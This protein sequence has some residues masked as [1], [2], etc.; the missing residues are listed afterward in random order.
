MLPVFCTLPGDRMVLFSTMP[1]NDLGANQRE[2]CLECLNLC[3]DDDQIEK[4]L[5]ALFYQNT[6]LICLK[7]GLSQPGPMHDIPKRNLR[8]V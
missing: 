2:A 6:Y 5:A 3:L 1:K 7:I 4:Q 8:Y